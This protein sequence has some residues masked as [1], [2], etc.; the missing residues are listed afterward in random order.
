MNPR[1]C[2]SA[3]TEANPALEPGRTLRCGRSG[4]KPELW[5]FL[6]VAERLPVFQCGLALCPDIAARVGKFG[7]AAFDVVQAIFENL[8]RVRCLV[9]P[10]GAEGRPETVYRRVPT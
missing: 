1:S 4:D 10:P 3:N 6:A 5:P 2:K 8:A 9:L 7:L